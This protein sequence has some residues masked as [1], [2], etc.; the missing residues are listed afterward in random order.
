MRVEAIEILRYAAADLTND[1]QRLIT[2]SR[3]EAGDT[4]IVGGG[5]LMVDGVRDPV[6]L[7]CYRDGLEQLLS[8]GYVRPYQ[9]GYQVTPAGD[10]A[11]RML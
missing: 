6:R 1:G 3:C 5:D 7:A 9:G 2:I 11:A 10:E 8:R 4:L